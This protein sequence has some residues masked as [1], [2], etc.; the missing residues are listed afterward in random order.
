MT[1]RQVTHRREPRWFKIVRAG[2]VIAERNGAWRVVRQV[3][4]R[5]NGQLHSVTLV[6]RR[7]S[8]THRC[9]TIVNRHDLRLRGFRLIAGARWECK[10]RVDKQIYQAIQQRNDPAREPHLL[11]CCDVEGIA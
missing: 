6:I 7:C 1:H 9:Y 10:T 2:D 11:T 3:T 5:A 4:R 8:W